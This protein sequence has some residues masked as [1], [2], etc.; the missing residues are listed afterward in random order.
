MAPQDLAGMRGPAPCPALWASTG[1]WLAFG[2]G[3]QFSPWGE[4]GEEGSCLAR[5]PSCLC[6]GLP[7]RTGVR[8]W[9]GV[10]WRKF[11]AYHR[12]CPRATIPP[13]LTFCPPSRASL[14]LLISRKNKN[15]NLYCAFPRLSGPLGVFTGVCFPLRGITRLQ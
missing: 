15:K 3:P 13:R 14:H 5:C 12:A 8:G 1:P 10:T 6:G 2:V 4:A 9:V 7:V 11:G